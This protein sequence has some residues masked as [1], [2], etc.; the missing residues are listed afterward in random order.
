MLKNRLFVIFLLTIS[1]FFT[2]CFEVIEEITMAKDGTGTMTL[3]VNLSQSKSRIAAIMLMDTIHGYK[4]PGKQEIQ[5]EIDKTVAQL[6]RMPGISNVK[7]TTDFTNFVADIRF[8]FKDVTDVNHLV[9]ALL[10]QYKV[11]STNIPTY[12]YNKEEARFTRNYSYSNDVKAQFNQLRNRDKEIFSTA[13]YVSILRFETTIT[14]YSNK[15][16]R[17]SKNQQAIIQRLAI[18][19]LINGQANISNQVQLSK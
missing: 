4:V 19:D 13:A 12:N 1:V 15:L 3:T 7:S 6:S 2:S 16:A 10:E 14:S 5:Q 9:K 18:P 11:K 17:I 8:S